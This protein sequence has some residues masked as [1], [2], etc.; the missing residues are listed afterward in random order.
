MVLFTLSC[1]CGINFVHDF[2]P[3]LGCIHSTT[4]AYDIKPSAG[5]GCYTG[6]DHT[7]IISSCRQI[8]KTKSNPALTQWLDFG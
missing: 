7:L 2:S 6:W 1:V 4:F 3:V 8:Q 5:T